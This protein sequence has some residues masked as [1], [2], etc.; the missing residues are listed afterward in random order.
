VVGD[1]GTILRTTNGGVTWSARVSGTTKDLRDAAMTSP[2]TGVIVGIDGRMLSATD[3]GTNWIR[4]ASNSA[5]SLLGVSFFG[6]SRGI[7]VG[8][9]GTILRTPVVVSVGERSAEGNPNRFQLEQNHPNPFNPVTTIRYSLPSQSISSAQERVGVGSY[10][11]LKVY[12][13]LGREVATLVNEVKQPGTY[14]VQWDAA[15]LAS[16]MYF[17]RLSTTNFVQTRK[18][19]LL[20]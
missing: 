6:T 20:R 19:V 8:S 1:T 14:M 10:V 3:G 12:D 11:T 16:G 5:N 2:T 15:G 9:D 18:L 17:Y 7:A 4:V 13:V